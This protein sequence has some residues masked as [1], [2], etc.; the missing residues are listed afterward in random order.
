[1]WIHHILFTCPSV[2]GRL[3]CFYLLAI[4]NN[5]AMKLVWFSFSFF[6]WGSYE[7]LCTSFCLDGCFHLFLLGRYPGVEKLGHFVNLCFPRW[8]LE[9]PLTQPPPPS[10]VQA[11]NGIAWE[12]SYYELIAL[13]S[14][15]ILKFL[16]LYPALNG[17]RPCSSHLRLLF[18]SEDSLKQVKVSWRV[19]NTILLP[20]LVLPICRLRFETVGF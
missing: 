14:W 13:I 1:M 16:K 3:C 20:S 10:V 2:E 9:Q 12:P 15:E 17:G 19:D 6:A 11:H 7:V 8:D 4:V 18:Q 5:V